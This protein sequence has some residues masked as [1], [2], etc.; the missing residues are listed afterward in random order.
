[1]S[2]LKSG[3]DVNH[4]H[5][6]RKKKFTPKIWVIIDFSFMF[7]RTHIYVLHCMFVEPQAPLI[8]VVTIQQ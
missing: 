5:R 4:R 1:V 6:T 7:H 3:Q 2:F 8:L